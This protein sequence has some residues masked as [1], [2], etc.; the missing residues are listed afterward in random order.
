MQIWL[1]TGIIWGLK[2]NDAGWEEW[3]LW[4][5]VFN[6]SDS[7]LINLGDSLRVSSYESPSGDSNMKPLGKRLLYSKLAI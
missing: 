3:G 2:I 5:D 7:D 4:A 6:T 1:H